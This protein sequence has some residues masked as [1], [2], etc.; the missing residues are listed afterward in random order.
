MRWLWVVVM[1]LAVMG[2]V[3]VGGTAQGAGDAAHF[4]RDG[5]GA[6]PRAL[7]GAFVAVADDRHAL[8]WNPAG[9]GGADATVRLGGTYEA[10]FGGLVT[11]NAVGV[12]IDADRWALGA[13]WVSSDMYSSF[14]VAFATAHDSL[15]IGL[16]PKLYLFGS[17]NQQA[18]GVGLDAG[19][20][21]RAEL[22]EAVVALGLVTKDVGW[23]TITWSGGGPPV[24]DHAAWVTRLGIAAVFPAPVGT[25]QITADVEA[26]L[27][28]PP[29]PDEPD[30]LTKA[31][32]VAAGCG[33]EWQA[34]PFSVRGGVSG[35]DLERPGEAV[36]RVSFGAGV[37]FEGIVLD[38]SW[39]STPLGGTYI[40]SAHV[41]I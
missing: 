26:G 27:R 13:G 21:L 22:D 19:L 31:L 5:V 12:T 32:Q 25:A 41:R 1:G 38:A 8:F 30:Y 37:A 39:V 29:R 9:I 10:R 24:V 6:R 16:S 33:L 11:L 34:G 28:R 40:L 15:R 23:T 20:I 14:S 18:S 4:L 7:G 35:L 36:L 17:A 3:H 2:S